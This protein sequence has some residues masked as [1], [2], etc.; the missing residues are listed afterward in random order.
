MILWLTI[1]PY[2]HV[3]HW[4]RI[5]YLDESSLTSIDKNQILALVINRSIY[6][7]VSAIGDM[8]PRTLAHIFTTFSN[9]QYL[10]FCASSIGNERL[11]LAN[12]CPG[13]NSSTLLELHIRLASFASCLYILDGRFNN[14]HTLHVDIQFI[15]PSDL[16]NNNQVD[17][18]G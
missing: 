5:F 18:F 9:L 2:K 8:N 13:I 3:F 16:R 14:L 11:S 15:W 4:L 10:N 1:K 7:K 6:G 12:P 17:C